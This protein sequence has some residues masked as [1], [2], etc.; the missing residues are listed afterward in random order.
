MVL[1]LGFC[2]VF[3]PV[4]VAEHKNVGSRQ[5]GVALG[6]TAVRIPCYLKLPVHVGSKDEASL[7]MRA[8]HGRRTSKPKWGSVLRCSASR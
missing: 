5:I 3:N 1:Q 2:P 7:S 4:V 6:D 8:A